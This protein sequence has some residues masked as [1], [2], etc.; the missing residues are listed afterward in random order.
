MLVSAFVAAIA[1]DGGVVMTLRLGTIE[2]E[3]AACR[4][5]WKGFGIGTLAAHVHHDVVAE[6]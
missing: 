4:A 6:G 5:R 1:C 3:A 2:Q